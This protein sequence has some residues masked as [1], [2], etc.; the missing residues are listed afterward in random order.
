MSIMNSFLVTLT[1]LTRIY[2]PVNINYDNESIKKSIWFY[3]VIGLIIGAILVGINYI[4]SMFIEHNEI[5][6]ILLL[7]TYV[8][9]SGGLHLDGLADVFDGFFSGRNKSKV[10]EIMS[11]SRL[12]TFGAIG[13]IIY[14]IVLYSTLKYVSY[15]ELFIFPIVG[16]CSCLI[17]ASISKYAKEKGLGQVIVDSTKFIHFIWAL[18]FSLITAYL[19]YFKLLLPI[20][21]TYI[22]I[23]I[24]SRVIHKRLSGITGD[25]LGC[26]IE[27]SQCIFLIIM[28]G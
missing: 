18:L 14:F 11:D 2:L 10:L 16:R 9:I 19:L 20:T 13:L 12:G 7:I 6:S 17:V 26:I 22:L 21:I 5:K 24:T 27:M 28:V 3:P 25:V 4:L 15:I 23:I 1:F 8:Y